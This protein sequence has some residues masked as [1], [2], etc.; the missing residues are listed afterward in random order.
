MLFA[1]LHALRVALSEIARVRRADQRD[2]RL[3]RRHHRRRIMDLEVLWRSS[4]KR[5]RDTPPEARCEPTEN[6]RRRTTETTA[7]TKTISSSKKKRKS[8]V[9]VLNW[10]F[11]R[12][13]NDATTPNRRS[14]REKNC[15]SRKVVVGEVLY[16]IRYRRRR[17]GE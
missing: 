8:T 6:W 13:T 17:F 2:R 14:E 7:E 5:V 1:S 4:Q 11:L 16:S 3:W 9:K 10:V 15:I 12:N